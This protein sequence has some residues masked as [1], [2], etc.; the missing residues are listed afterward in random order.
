MLRRI[1]KHCGVDMVKELT[2]EGARFFCKACNDY[3]PYDEYDCEPFCP[4]CDGAIEVCTKC[5]QAYFCNK[6]GALVSRTKI[7]WKETGK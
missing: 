4:D 3:T 7:I 1:C 5:S 6:C 2:A